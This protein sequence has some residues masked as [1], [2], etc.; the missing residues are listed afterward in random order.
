M[1]NPYIDNAA[2]FLVEVV[3]GIYILVVMLRFL[4]QLFRAD[5][6]NP[7]SQL[8]V[9]LTN[10]PLQPLRRVV[11]GV[12]G[13]DTASIVLLIALQAVE[14]W[15]VYNIG[16]ATTSP[17]GLVLLTIAELLALTLNVFMVSIFIIVVISWIN[18]GSYNPMLSLL[19]SL[20]EPLLRPL[21]QA[22]PPAGGFDF[23][24]LLAL[25][26]VMLLKLLVVAPIHDQGKLLMVGAFGPLGV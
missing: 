20:T 2:T 16:G 13:I 23:S 15:L 4:F 17:A 22:L 5:F 3:F 24:P 25:I 7:V 10:P 14:L 11:P 26:L 18:P 6:Y 1:G 8:L 12:F 19:H 9:K 21:R